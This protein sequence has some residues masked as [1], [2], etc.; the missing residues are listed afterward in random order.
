MTGRT[1]ILVVEDEAH[2]RQGLADLLNTWGYDVD[3]AADGVEVL[4]KLLHLNPRSSSPTCRCHAWG[5]WTY[6]DGF[7]NSAPALL[8]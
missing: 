6:S 5:A 1:R 7:R 3:M 4:R 2:E 8:S